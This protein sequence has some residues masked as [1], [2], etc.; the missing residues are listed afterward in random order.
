MFEDLVDSISKLWSWRWPEVDGEITETIVERIKHGRDNFTYRLG[1]A[2]VF[3][4]NA[5][6]PYTGEDFWSPAFFG[7]RRV[8]AAAHKFHKH[9]Q[10]L[11]R[12]RPSDPSINRLDRSVWRDL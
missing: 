12:Y 6:G 10:V 5:D 11:V 4:V 1:I 7:K 8:S 3:S 9:Q 2:F